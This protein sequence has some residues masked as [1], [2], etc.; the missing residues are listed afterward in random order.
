M[1]F[2]EMVSALREGK[3]V[4]LKEWKEIQ[5]IYMPKNETE[6]RA[7][8]DHFVN[9][10][11][12]NFFSDDWEIVEEKKK[13]KLR[14]LTEKEFQNW[15]N[16]KCEA[17]C[18]HCIFENVGCAEW[19]NN[20]WVRNKNLY[21]NKFLDQEIEIEIADEPLLTPKEKEYLEN[22]LIP[23]K[24]RIIYI[25]KQTIGR[26]WAEIII[27]VESI[28]AEKFYDLISLPVFEKDKYYK[29]LVNNKPY[30]KEELELFKR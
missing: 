16:E 14:D 7:E 26:N 30:T 20:C 2:E 24:D 28:I 18:E 17:D 15:K 12:K 22:V 23:Y 25:K 6:L 4:R 8:D 29:N 9:L 5:Y 19:K 1:K 3:K 27:K 10:S 21:S 13:I 11:W